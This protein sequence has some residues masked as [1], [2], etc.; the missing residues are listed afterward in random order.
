LGKIR[1]LSKRMGSRNFGLKMVAFQRCFVE[2]KLFVLKIIEV[3]ENR[4]ET[5]FGH[6]TTCQLVFLEVL[7]EKS[8][9]F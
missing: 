4:L 9:V 3:S 5:G 7:L 8:F 6:F 2:R 1:V